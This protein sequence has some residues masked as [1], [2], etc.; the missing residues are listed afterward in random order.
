MVLTLGGRRRRTATKKEAAE[1]TKKSN[2]VVSVAG[3]I[4]TYWTV[5]IEL[6]FYMKNNQ[7]KKG[8]GAGAACLDGLSNLLTKEKKQD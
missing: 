2:H 3:L 6:E 1:E 8:K 7:R 4:D 5:K